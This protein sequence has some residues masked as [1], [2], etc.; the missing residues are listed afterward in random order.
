MKPNFA[1]KRIIKKIKIQEYYFSS[2]R[3]LHLFPFLARAKRPLCN[4][5]LLRRLY[6]LNKKSD[7]CH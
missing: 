7:F 1:A 2:R 4:I 3:F 5:S 6:D